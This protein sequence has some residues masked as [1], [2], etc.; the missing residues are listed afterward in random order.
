MP[1]ALNRTG[2]TQTSNEGRKAP[3]ALGA[4]FSPQKL[5]G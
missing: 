1:F 2:W 3:A 4:T 5:P